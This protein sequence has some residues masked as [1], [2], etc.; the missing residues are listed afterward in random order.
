MAENNYCRIALNNKLSLV[1]AQER[2]TW[3][4]GVARHSMSKFGEGILR[5]FFLN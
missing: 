2:K 4:Y 1:L 5:I 3:Q